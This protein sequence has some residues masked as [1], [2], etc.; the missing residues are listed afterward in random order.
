MGPGA[1]APGTTGWGTPD[2]G[3]L[4]VVRC[5]S[6]GSEFVVTRHTRLRTPESP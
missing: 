2:V 5:P 4:P 3:D 6:A 1:R